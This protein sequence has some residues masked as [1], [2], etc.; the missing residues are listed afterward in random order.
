MI[1]S[2]DHSYGRLPDSINN[3]FRNTVSGKTIGNNF[4]NFKIVILFRLSKFTFIPVMTGLS[5]NIGSNKNPLQTGE[6]GCSTQIIFP[7]NLGHNSQP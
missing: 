1:A 3:S 5:F 2:L 7:F 6:L 4:P